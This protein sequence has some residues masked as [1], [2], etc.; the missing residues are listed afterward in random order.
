MSDRAFRVQL[1][2]FL[3]D[4]GLEDPRSWARQIVLDRTFW[5]L[6]FNR[7]AFEDGGEL[8]DSVC[9]S[10]VTTDLPVLDD[11]N[12]D[13]RL[14]QLIGQQI[15]PLGA[16][17]LK[18]FSVTFHVE[19][20]P[21]RV[22]G[23]AKFVAQVV[24]KQQGP[25]GLAKAKAIWRTGSQQATVVFSK[26]SKVEWEEGWHFVRIFPQTEDGDLIPLVDKDGKPLPWAS[27]DDPE[28]QRLNESDLFYVLPSDDVEVEPPQRAIPND[29]SVLHALIRLKFTAIGEGSDPEDV[30]LQTVDW[31]QRS[32]HGRPTGCDQIEARFARDGAVH[33]PVSRHL[34]LIEQKILADAS[35][36]L[37]WRV[38]VTLGVA[39]QS[40]AEIVKW[41]R[42]TTMPEFLASRHQYFQ[43]ILKGGKQ[44]VTQATDL[45]TLR[46]LVVEYAAKY[47]A[48]VEELTEQT[49]AANPLESQKAFSDLRRFLSIDTVYLAITDHR[50]R[51]REATLVAPTHPLRALWLVTWAELAGHWLEQSKDAPKEMIVP[52]REALLRQLAP[53]S[54]PPV[55]PTDSGSALLAVDNLNPFWTLY[56]P[57]FEEDP[58]GLLGEICS[59]FGIRE[60]PIGGATVDG[61]Y[62][63]SR[64]R[65]YLVQH[66]YVRTL[67]I[68]AFNAGRGTVLADML[69]ALQR[70]P[71][72]EDLRYDVRLFVPDAEAPGVGEALAR[73]LIV[74][75]KHCRQG[76]RCL[77]DAGQQ[78]SLPEAPA[79]HPAVRRV[80]GRSRALCSAFVHDV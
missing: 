14:E 22:Q 40:T 72:F 51:K 26:L 24:S 75:G 31:A 59:A 55:L 23:L 35:G 18:K 19:P 37:C 50:Q 60:P 5:P 78:P 41:P 28:V 1:A 15:L 71:D 32:A 38:P 69:L 64:V 73:A 27:E 36:P 25:V 9:V 67:V 58:R 46:T 2:S 61:D 11:D 42:S 70:M 21:S 53:V 34:K 12:A 57:S 29:E 76:S 74:V 77:C 8:P 10:Q 4:A 80:S 49:K 16:K 47:L 68:N 48:V 65:R 33:V 79:G 39:G 63:A 17:G 13:Q 6:A 30:A 7:W 62:L 52:T 3:A 20:H 54:F 43:A 44:L 66:P 56:A 45:R